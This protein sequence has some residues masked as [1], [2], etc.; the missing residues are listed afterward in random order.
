MPRLLDKSFLERNQKVIGVLGIGALLAGSAF[1]LLLSGGVFAR[2]YHVTAYFTDAAGIQPGDAV[3]VAGLKAGTVKGMHIERGQVAV[4]LAVGKSVDLPRD[5]SADIVIQTLLGK[6]AVNLVAGHS[7][8][9][10]QG[11][12]TIPASRTTTPV[13][14]TELND[15]SVRLMNQSDAQSLNNVL[16]EVTDVTEGKRQEV[17]QLIDGLNKVVAAVD[18]RRTQLG[19]LIDALNTLSGTLAGKDQTIVSLIDR[20][21]AVLGNLA[22]HQQDLQTLLVATDSAS[23][24]TADLVSRNRATLDSALTSLHGVLNVLADHQL[25]LAATVDYLDQSVQGYSSVGYSC[26]G[27]R[28]ASSCSGE[29]FPNR[30]ANIFVQS[31]GPLGVDEM[32]GQ[33]GVVDQIVDQI[34]GL[35]CLDEPA[36]GST[37]GA[38]GSVGGPGGKGGGGPLPLPSLPLPTPTIGLGGGST[39]QDLPGNVGDLIDS[40]L[41]GLG[42]GGGH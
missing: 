25:D 19:G 11:G 30:W 13:D 12:D 38:G 5:S 28:T 18:A 7:K 37:P 1:A 40:A 22:A 2:T 33:C 21:N 34:L 29:E 3:T 42:G 6:R 9:P 35:N 15:I 32:L 27:T 16:K 36:S 8:T 26:T 4:D 20:L 14:I 31:L 39:G 24:D 17:T 23:H 10:L 41:G